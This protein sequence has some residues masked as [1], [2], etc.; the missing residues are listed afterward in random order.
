MVILFAVAFSLRF[1]KIASSPSGVFVDEASF[2]YNAYSILQT[3]K[4]EHGVFMPLVFKAFGDQKLPVYAYSIVPFVKLFGL[5]NMAVRMPSVIA[6]SIMGIM[7]F[8]LLLELGFNLRLSFLGSLIAITSP[9]SL[10]M[11]RFGYES[12]VALTFFI[13]GIYVFFL[14]RRKNSIPLAILCGLLMGIT[15][16]SYIAY[17]L[18]TPLILTVLM[19]QYYIKQKSH[20]T[21]GIVLLLLF[22]SQF[23]HSSSAYFQNKGPQDCANQALSQ[24]WE[25]SCK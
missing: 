15:W 13:A 8:L 16:Y 24:I 11:S 18:V 12:N 10:T 2:G 7:L 23:R 17:R 20:K 9:W 4:D 19:I 6:G 21:L 3:G 5:G 14:S 1:Y 22:L 25:L